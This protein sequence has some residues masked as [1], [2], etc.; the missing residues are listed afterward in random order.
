MATL[1]TCE[2]KT[3]SLA[4]CHAGAA[5]LGVSGIKAGMTFWKRRSR[6]SAQLEVLLVMSR[7]MVTKCF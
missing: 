3:V 1:W 6:A 2:P 5:A 4:C 7:A